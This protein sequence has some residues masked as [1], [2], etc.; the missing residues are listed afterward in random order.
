MNMAYW[1]ND[2]EDQSTW[3]ET[4]QCHFF[5]HVSYMVWLGIEL[6][7]LQW[8]ANSL[9]CGVNEIKVYFRLSDTM[10]FY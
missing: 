9:V 4:Q 3:T 7:P 6:G 8:E 2:G 5:H 1:R 10:F